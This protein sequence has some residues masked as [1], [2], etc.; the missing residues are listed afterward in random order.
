MSK[1]VDFKEI[2]R[3]VVLSEVIGRYGLTL[4]K[5]GAEYICNCPF[6]Q[7]SSAS[8]TV[9]DRKRIYKCFGCGVSGD[10]FD[11]LINYGGLSWQEAIKAAQ[12]PFNTEA[13]VYG[14]KPEYVKPFEWTPIIP[15]SPFKDP[16]TDHH[17]Y[18]KAS[19]VWYYRNA[20]GQ[21]LCLICRFDVGSKKE[22]LPLTFCKNNIGTESWRWLGLQKPRPLYNLHFIALRTE[23]IMIV[24]GEKSADAAHALFPKYTAT[25]WIG[26]ADG[27]KATDFSPLFGRD[28]VLW[29]DNDK[30]KI[31][32]T[33]DR[34]GT[35]MLFHELPG[36]KAMFAIVAILKD[37]CPSIKWV[38]NAEEFESG[39][40]VADASWTIEEANKYL[41]EN[42]IDVPQIQEYVQPEAVVIAPPIVDRRDDPE[43]KII[44]LENTRDLGNEFDKRFGETAV[45]ATEIKAARKDSVTE[46][47]G[48]EKNDIEDLKTPANNIPPDDPDNP[49]SKKPKG[50]KGGG[51][52]R[53]LGY[54]KDVNVNLYHFYSYAAKTVISLSPS[55]MTKPNL[56]Q[57]APLDWWQGFFPRH[58]KKGEPTDG[59]E[60]DKAQNWL[61]NESVKS[62]IFNSKL[63]RGRGAWID[64]D[65]VVIHSGEKLVVNGIPVDFHDHNSKYIYEIG[66]DMGFKM[67]DPLTTKQSGVLLEI[68]KLVNWEREIDAY[69]LAGW[70]VVAPMC[71]ALIWRP[72][73][74]LTGSAG[75]GKSWIF[76]KL[77]RRLLGESAMA[78][79]GETSEPGLRQMLKHD[80]LPVVFDE[81]EGEDRKAQDRMADVL[82][83]MRSS[84]ASDG[85][86]MAKGTS[87]GRANTYKIRSCFAF[88]S[89]TIQINHQSDR[90]RIT[91]LSLKK[92]EKSELRDKRWKELVK[93]YQ[94]TVT[95]QYATKLRA[96]TISMLPVILKNAETFSAAAAAELGQQRAGDQ[97]GV[98]LAGAFSLRS[99]KV[100][101]YKEALAW[102]QQ[103]DWSE[104]KSQE[105]TRD[106]LSLI[107]HILSQ[108]TRIESS[109][110][111]Q[112]RTIGEL[113]LLAA[114]VGVDKVIDMGQA[115]ERLNRLGMKV[116]GIYLVIGNSV[117]AI[118]KYLAGTHWAKNYNKILMR[119]DGAIDCEPT[120]FASGLKIRA[121]KIPI[122][123]LFKKEQGAL[124][125]ILANKIADASAPIIIANPNTDD[126]PPF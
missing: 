73:I 28:I 98:L 103:K 97:V 79:Q 59:F 43:T 13:H 47:I 75:S 101:S 92:P 61:I 1:K 96:R 126:K 106:E 39:W 99:S 24:E 31:H 57:L 30:D 34:K 52:F 32:K 70:C 72:H 74:W 56:L 4:K 77:V 86:I 82:A 19:K 119:L 5:R 67:A 100:I 80:A 9:N 37:H 90:T 88:A 18:G 65:K 55:A 41:E 54:Q 83:L 69:L 120:R 89:I 121:V 23:P 11:F 38:R 116:A 16:V 58:S 7:E 2:K 111:P 3:S 87:G 122:D 29:P 44:R 66:E 104:E 114:G 124:F 51:F 17:N 12:D 84:S 14:E 50:F 60:L 27:V 85:G 64:G 91:V 48:I 6:H 68:L 42:L 45:P 20:Q 35:T 112:E 33:G 117:D 76:E 21:P 8:F 93:K 25:T 115:N 113:V 109:H 81:A 46:I 125:E 26:G 105:A 15:R 95:E 110:G 49:D 36:N 10:V 108:V 22:V 102:I 71:G 78:V 62:R 107:Q 123:I 118:N 40:D 63:I 94:D 53:M